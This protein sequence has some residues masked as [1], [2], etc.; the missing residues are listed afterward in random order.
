V[1]RLRRYRCFELTVTATVP[2]TAPDDAEIVPVPTLVAR[3]PVVREPWEENDPRDG[4]TDHVGAI[5]T[6]LPNRSLP[7]AESVTVDPTRT[8]TGAGLMLIAARGA[9]V[10]VSVWLAPA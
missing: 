7:V 4:V 5:T 2:R 10:T 3:K 6:A 9:A 1:L 8:C